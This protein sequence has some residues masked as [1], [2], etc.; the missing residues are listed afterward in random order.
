MGLGFWKLPSLELLTTQNQCVES[1]WN[2]L[3]AWR[4]MVLFNREILQNV[5]LV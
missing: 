5:E 1:G 2:A 3:V 4:A